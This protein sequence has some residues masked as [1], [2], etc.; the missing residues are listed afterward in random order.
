VKELCRGADSVSICL[1]K[2]LGAPLG[3]VLVGESE[4]IRLAKRARKRVGGGMR[5]VGVVAAMGTYALHHNVERLEED[6]LRARRFAEEL[7]KNGFRQP[8][9]GKVDTNIVYFGLP[10]D[11]LI[12][13]EKL[14][15][16]LL[17]EYGVKLSGGYSKGGELFRIVTHLDVDD[18]C[19]ERALN[20]IISLCTGKK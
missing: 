17:D 19:I 4:F 1:S 5:Q 16:R 20:G 10:E 7:H 18:E 6:H 2:G 9:E 13:K 15:S 8:Q 14:Q 11:S 3:S 12:E